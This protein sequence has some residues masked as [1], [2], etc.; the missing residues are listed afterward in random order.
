MLR[1]FLHFRDLRKTRVL[2]LAMILL[3]SQGA[4]SPLT[5]ASAAKDEDFGL[6]RKMFDH[7][8]EHYGDLQNWINNYAG[9]INV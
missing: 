4:F 8:F 5:F 1:M 9:S 2:L 3:L 7:W 6:M